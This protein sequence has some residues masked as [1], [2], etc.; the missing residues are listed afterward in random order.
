MA[1]ALLGCGACSHNNAM[2][3][4]SDTSEASEASEACGG[5]GRI[6]LVC[7]E[8][9]RMDSV[10]RQEA[11]QALEPGLKAYK[12]VIEQAPSRRDGQQGMTLTAFLDAWS[13]SRAVEMFTPEVKHRWSTLDTSLGAELKTLWANLDKQLPALAKPN[14]VYAVVSP[15]SESL[16]VVDDSVLLIASNHYLGSDFEGYSHVEPYRRRLKEPSRAPVDVAEALIDIYTVDKY[17]Q[18]DSASLNSPEIRQRLILEGAKMEA[19]CRLFPEM[20]PQEVM[21]FTPSEWEWLEAHEQELWGAI[22][23]QG[24]LRSSDYMD[25]ER[26]FDPAPSTYILHHDAP[27]RAG[28]YVAYK[29]IQSLLKKEGVAIASS[30]L[31]APAFYDNPA[32]MKRARYNPK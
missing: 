31:L 25:I 1:L 23:G 7:F 20:S 26:L 10:G 5:V 11:M 32:T 4:A 18:A 27:G 12:A 9:P 15:Y 21:G 13:Q 6:D 16:Y 8:W 22:V 29:I 28:R 30:D 17:L 24:L 19:L 14:H 2:T 3:I